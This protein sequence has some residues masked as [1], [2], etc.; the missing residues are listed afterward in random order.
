MT[1]SETEVPIPST[2]SDAFAVRFSGLRLSYGKT[3]ALDGI[4]LDIPSG[5]LVGLIGPDG[6]G[7]SSLLS[8][9]LSVCSKDKTWRHYNGTFWKS[10]GI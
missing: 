3:L 8:L 6:V 5:R 7:K 2:D 9:V 1:A 10:S 4:S